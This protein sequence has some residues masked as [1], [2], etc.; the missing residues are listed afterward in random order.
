MRLTPRTIWATNPPNLETSQ[1]R[2]HGTESFRQNQFL[3]R[4]YTAINRALKKQI[5]NA[6]EPAFLTPIKNQLAGFVQ[7]TDLD[8]MNYLFKAYGDIKD[9]DLE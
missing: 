5:I 1:E 2:T 9:T 8:M 3:F 6:M 4:H 7:V